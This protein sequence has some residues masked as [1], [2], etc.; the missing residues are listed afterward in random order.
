MNLGR[1]WWSLIDDRPL[2]SSPLRKFPFRRPPS[3]TQ[4]SLEKTE[5]KRIGRWKKEATSR[6]PGQ[7]SGAARRAD[8]RSPTRVQRSSRGQ[9]SASKSRPS[10][11]QFVGGLLSSVAKVTNAPEVTSQTGP[12]QRPRTAEENIGRCKECLSLVNPAATLTSKMI[13]PQFRSSCGAPRC[14]CLEV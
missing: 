13:E 8:R 1:R 3:L 10:T 14:L 9:R 6:G 11:S 5:K 4:T 12:S 2:P 7:P